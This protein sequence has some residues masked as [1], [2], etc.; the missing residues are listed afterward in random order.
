MADGD[1][2]SAATCDRCL[3]G[4]EHQLEGM[5]KGQEDI[6]QLIADDKKEAARRQMLWVGIASLAV[7]LLSNLDK[8]GAL[9]K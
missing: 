7:G 6:K 1:F 5:S 9:F 2:I 8:I 3:K 4:I